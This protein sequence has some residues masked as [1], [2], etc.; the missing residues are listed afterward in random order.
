MKDGRIACVNPEAKYLDP[1]NYIDYPGLEK[2]NEWLVNLEK[3][4]HMVYLDS[5][6]ISWVEYIQDNR[7]KSPLEIYRYLNDLKDGPWNFSVEAFTPMYRHA[8]ALLAI[9]K[10][11]ELSNFIYVKKE[12]V[13]WTPVQQPLPGSG[14]D[15]KTGYRPGELHVIHAIN[16][17]HIYP[18]QS[19][20]NSNDGPGNSNDEVVA[21]ETATK[22]TLSKADALRK[23]T[24]RK[25]LE[26]G[27]D[28]LSKLPFDVEV[29]RDFQDRELIDLWE[30]HL[31]YLKVEPIARGYD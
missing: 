28:F 25:Y 2:I 11:H 30:Q 27:N 17:P 6:F 5:K 14:L 20:D 19:E 10:D 18:L 7:E 15:S 4:F 24:I 3:Q 1:A 21:L 29:I 23:D 31:A 22:P 13:E 16:K 8:K 9:Y 12:V 26:A